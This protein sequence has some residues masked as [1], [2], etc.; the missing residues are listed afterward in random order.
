MRSSLQ[1]SHVFGIVRELISLVNNGHVVS[2]IG[3]CMGFKGFRAPE[4]LCKAACAKY[5][6]GT[7]CACREAY[8]GDP[9]DSVS[10]D[11]FEPQ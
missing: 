7:A 3:F 11:S 8:D 10:P 6:F 5:T 9:R 4:A 2:G 1:G